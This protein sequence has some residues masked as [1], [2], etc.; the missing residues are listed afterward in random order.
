M[1]VDRKG[2]GQWK[3]EKDEC[4]FVERG[5]E[6]ERGILRGLSDIIYS[7]GEAGRKDSQSG[8]ALNGFPTSPSVS[9]RMGLPE[10]ETR[11]IWPR[12]GCKLD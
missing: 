10:P 4:W 7:C 8:Y 9:V 3:P 5:R 2:G 12:L 6:R 11:G 1:L